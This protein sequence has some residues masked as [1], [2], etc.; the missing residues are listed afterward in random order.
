MVPQSVLQPPFQH[1]PEQLQPKILQQFDPTP[2][3][4]TSQQC[5]VAVGTNETKGRNAPRM[6][7]FILESGLLSSMLEMG[8]MSVDQAFIVV[9]II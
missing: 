2:A 9:M 7:N 3:E 6:K 1:G 5:A 4:A 8:G